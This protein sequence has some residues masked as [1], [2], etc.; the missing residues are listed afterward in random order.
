VGPPNLMY[1]I[2][3]LLR[4]DIRKDFVSDSIHAHVISWSRRDVDEIFD[5]LNYYT[6]WGVKSIPTFRDNLSTFL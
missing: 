5:F 3:V 4:R 1:Q 6:A 2:V